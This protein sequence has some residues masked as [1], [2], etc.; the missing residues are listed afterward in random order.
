[1]MADRGEPDFSPAE[2]GSRFVFASSCSPSEIK[3]FERALFLSLLSSGTGAISHT[4]KPRF[5]RAALVLPHG[6]TVA[7]DGHRRVELLLEQNRHGVIEQIGDGEIEFPV[8]IEV[9]GHD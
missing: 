8:A 3:N 7:T 6:Q 2:T 9:C 1:M 5:P 4:R